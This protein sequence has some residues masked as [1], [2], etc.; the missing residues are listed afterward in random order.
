M[1]LSITGYLLV[2]V[3][4]LFWGKRLYGSWSAAVVLAVVSPIPFAIISPIISL[5]LWA[6]L[7]RLLPLFGSPD[8]DL[9]NEWIQGGSIMLSG[10][11]CSLALRHFA[12]TE[13]VGKKEPNP[14]LEPTTPSDRGSP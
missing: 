13:G 3:A 9:E 11:I 12:R 1:I 10:V 7:G 2:F 14:P 4:A 5:V 8:F 6:F